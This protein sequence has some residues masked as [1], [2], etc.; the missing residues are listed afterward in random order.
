MRQHH[1]IQTVGW[2][3]PSSAVQA[4]TVQWLRRELGFW[5][6]CFEFGLR[7]PSVGHAVAAQ[8]LKLRPTQLHSVVAKHIAQE[9]VSLALL[10]RQQTRRDRLAQRSQPCLYCFLAFY[11]LTLHEAHR[12]ARIL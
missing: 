9:F 12:T 2:P 11:N 8:R 5:L 7:Q 10:P 4:Q 6:T 3:R 1:Q